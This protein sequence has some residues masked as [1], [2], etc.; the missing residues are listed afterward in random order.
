MTTQT[1]TLGLGVIG[2]GRAF[3]L[4]LPTLRRDQRFKLV[5]ASTP[6]EEARDKF[7]RDFAAVSYENVRDLCHDPKVDVV[8]I[9][10]PHQF[11]V[12]HVKLAAEAGK[13]VLVEK[14]LAI[15]LEEG[16][17]MVDAATKAGI[18]LIVGP[19]HSFDE[20]ILQAREIIKTGELGK[21]RMIQA[22]NYTDF[23]YRP[24]RAEELDTA[25]GGGVVFS[26]AIH[27]IDVVRLLGGGMLRSVRALT[28]SWDTNRPTEGAYSALLTFADNSFASLTYSGYGH[29]DSDELMGG[30]S[31]LG[32]RKN[33]D[34]YARARR[35]IAGVATAAEELDLKRKRT[36]EHAGPPENEELADTNE[37]F[38]PIIVCC[39]RG[40][41]RPLAD[42]VMIYGDEQKRF[43]KIPAPSIP[44]VNV[45]NELYDAVVDDGSPLHSGAWGLASLEAS[46]AIL[47]SAAEGG[48]EINMTMQVPAPA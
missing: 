40:D 42:G 27:Q 13:H 33:M 11:H 7:V 47:A 4:M 1:R 2:L 9:A 26:Q 48:K 43:Q 41:L 19:S 3:M 30:Y 20:P 14:P 35:S 36:F 29:F 31:E 34:D 24:R 22:F 25:Q 32:M 8:Y 37:H 44:R 46:M 21:V 17:S 12:E 10:S 18:H 23:L 16:R 15:S 6:S 39:E 28:G 38:G 5:A 45:M